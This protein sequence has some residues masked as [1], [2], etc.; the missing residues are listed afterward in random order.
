MNLVSAGVYG[1]YI[2]KLIK[3]RKWIIYDPNSTP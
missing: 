1:F 3:S 2:K